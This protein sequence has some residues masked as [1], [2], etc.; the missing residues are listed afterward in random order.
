MI[1]NT[2]T[3]TWDKTTDATQDQIEFEKLKLNS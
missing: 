3:Q 2:I 1:I